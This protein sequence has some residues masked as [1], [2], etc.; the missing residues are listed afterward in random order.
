M[1]VLRIRVW[2]ILV[3]VA[4]CAVFLAVFQYRRGSYDPTYARL[5]QVRYADA[6][7]KVAAIRE[8]MD[9]DAT[10]FEVIQTLR[11]ALGDADPAV[12]AVAVQA[13]AVAIER[14]AAL[15]NP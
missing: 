14:N 10:G 9:S 13:M 11:G 6:D 7:T 12:R 5:R 2:H 8:L 4:A 1:V 15:K 3:L